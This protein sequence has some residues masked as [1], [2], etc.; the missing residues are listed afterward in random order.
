[1]FSSAKIHIEFICILNV[2]FVCIKCFVGL[3]TYK[4]LIFLHVYSIVI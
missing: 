1:M 3:N 4:Q 2:H